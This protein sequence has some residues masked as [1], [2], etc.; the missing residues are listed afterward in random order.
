MDNLCPLCRKPAQRLDVDRDAR[1]YTC[2]RCVLFRIDRSS[3]GYL[4]EMAEPNAAITREM[5]SKRAA[6]AGPAE[7]LLLRE[8]GAGDS[9]DSRIIVE[10]VKR[11]T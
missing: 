6:K 8:P 4:L 10:V 9:I 7:M 11:S 5:L 1:I 2:A 3:E